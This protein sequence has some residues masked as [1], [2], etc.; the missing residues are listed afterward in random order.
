MPTSIETVLLQQLFTMLAP[1]IESAVAGLIKGLAMHIPGGAISPSGMV[2]IDPA[3][4][5]KMIEA[6]VAKIQ[7]G[8]PA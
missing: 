7:A 3:A 1:M 4:L 2:T 8:K 6:E 5:V